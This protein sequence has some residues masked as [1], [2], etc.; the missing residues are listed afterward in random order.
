MKLINKFQDIF[1]YNPNKIIQHQ[2]QKQ[3]K[4]IFTTPLKWQQK[5]PNSIKQSTIDYEFH[6]YLNQIQKLKTPKKSKILQKE[7]RN[8]I[9]N[10]QAQS[11]CL[12]NSIIL[13]YRI[14]EI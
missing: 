1:T 9:S 2:Q 13:Q 11:P 12:F 5:I 10:T 14:N 4:N 3:N 6:Y 7:A 8:F